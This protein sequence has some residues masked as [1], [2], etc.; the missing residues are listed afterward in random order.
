MDRFLRPK[1]PKIYTKSVRKCY[2]LMLSQSHTCRVWRSIVETC[3]YGMCSRFHSPERGLEFSRN[4][5]SFL[6]IQ[7]S[8]TPGLGNDHHIT[9]SLYTGHRL[10]P[11]LHE[12]QAI[13]LVEIQDLFVAHDHVMRWI[14]DP[15]LG[16]VYQSGPE[17]EEN[18]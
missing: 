5:N 3:R 11:T 7:H 15:F 14:Y 10:D 9:R 18:E 12:C 8:V 6:N 2:E 1:T 17:N 13:G 16:A 4:G